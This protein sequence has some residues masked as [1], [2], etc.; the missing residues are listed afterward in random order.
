MAKAGMPWE[1]ADQEPR[2]RCSPVKGLIRYT[3]IVIA[4]AIG[5]A[6]PAELGRGVNS[7]AVGA[8]WLPAEGGTHDG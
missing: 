4:A 6:S 1:G 3:R 8:P 2:S 5:L 7:A